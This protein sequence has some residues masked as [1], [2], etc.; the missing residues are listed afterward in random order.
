MKNKPLL[1]LVRGAI[2][3]AL[4]VV[5]TLPFAVFAYGPIQLRL[6]E[7]LTITPYFW[8]EA[9]P[10]LAIG[11]LLA[12]ILG[13]PFGVVDWILGTLATLI[14]AI[15]TYKLRTKKLWIAAIPP[16]VVNAIIIS[17]YLSVMV[18]FFETNNMPVGLDGFTAVV[19]GFGLSA[20]LVTAGWVAIGQTVAIYGLGIPFA[21]GLKRVGLVDEN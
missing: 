14:A 15:L 12:N 18:G 3:S 21:L 17:I 19:K 4:Y 10:G 9:I 5:L 7:L 11:C 20:Y 6:A 2:I 1:M 16:V 8:P 13:S